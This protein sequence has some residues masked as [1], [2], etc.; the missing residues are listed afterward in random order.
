MDKS[1][2]QE[3]TVLA[4]VATRDRGKVKIH[5][6]R[7][8]LPFGT[9]VAAV[10]ARRSSTIPAHIVQLTAQEVQDINE[11]PK[12]IYFAEGCWVPRQ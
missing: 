8:R 5:T 1:I 9:G 11:F 6:E 7:L 4:N 12:Q 10:H 2:E 3:K